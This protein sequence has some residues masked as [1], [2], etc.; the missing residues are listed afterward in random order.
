VRDVEDDLVRM[1]KR[2]AAS[3]G[4][5]AEAEHRIILEQALRPEHESLVATARRLVAE[6]AGRGGPTGTE[7]IRELRDRNGHFEA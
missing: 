4:R 1:L 7:I 2:R 6:T 3:H 5:S